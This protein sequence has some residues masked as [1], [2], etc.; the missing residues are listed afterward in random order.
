MADFKLHLAFERAH[1]GAFNKVDRDSIEGVQAWQTTIRPL[2][3]FD[4][5]GDQ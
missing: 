3:Q 1:P 4:Q 2:S 5:V